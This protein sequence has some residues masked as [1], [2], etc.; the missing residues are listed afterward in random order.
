MQQAQGTNQGPY[1]VFRGSAFQHGYG[2]GGIFR[3]FFTWAIPLLK[4]HA[5]PLAKNV[6]KEVVSNIAAIATDAIEGKN[7][8]TSAKENFKKSIQKINPNQSGE[9]YKKKRNLRNKHKFYKR[10]KKNDIFS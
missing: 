6:G 4:Q 3:K 9:G 5:L 7:V 2:L 8:E 10:I 1:P